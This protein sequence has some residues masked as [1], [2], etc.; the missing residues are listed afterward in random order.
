MSNSFYKNH[1]DDAV[2]WK[3]TP[4][5]RGEFLFSF[6]KEQVFNLFQ[7]YPYKLTA[8][9]KKIFDR[10]NPFWAEFFADRNSPG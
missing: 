1:K 5:V 9:Q 6:D 8:E 4:G 3:R 2:W 10:E 7:D